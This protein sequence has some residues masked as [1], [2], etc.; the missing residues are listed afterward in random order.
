MKSTV[1]TIPEKQ[2]SQIDN[3]PLADVVSGLIGFPA[4]LTAHDL[5]IFPLLSQSALSLEEICQIKNL[6][7]RAAA[8]MLSMCVSTGL[9][10]KTSGLYS[11]TALSRLYLLKESPYYYGSF[12]DLLINNY[13]S[14][15]YP[16]IKQAILANQ[17]Q[18]YEG[19]QDVFKVHAEQEELAAAFTR[20]MHSSSNGPAQVWVQIV[21]LSQYKTMLDVGGGSG[22]HS[23][24]ALE[25]W[26]QL[27]ATLLDLPSV[28]KVAGEIATNHNLSDRLSTR[29]C[30]I[31]QDPF[32]EAD[33]HFY[34]QIYHD[35]P[36]DKCLF[37]T[38][39]SYQS[40]PS[41]GRIILHEVL[42]DDDK[43]GPLAA[44]ASSIGMLLWTQGQQ[45]SGLELSEMLQEAGF[46]NIEVIKT[47]FSYWSIV[48]AHKA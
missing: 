20:A 39:K 26:P 6:T 25:Q 10:S 21:N 9:L 24:A 31:W 36:E 22:A 34:S 38:K 4:I 18:A 32:P 14:I 33:I 30:N 47:G 46:M 48:T 43:S 41:G 17:S 13:D 35:W 37:L 19:K 15:T 11:L 1:K 44:A 42:Y 12:L 7:P 28:C 27:K 8:A 2:H 3:K 40:L 29:I 16:S 5:E 45:Y 23:I